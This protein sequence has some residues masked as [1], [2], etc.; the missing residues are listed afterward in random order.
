LAF[1]EIFVKYVWWF[2]G[3]LYGTL[4]IGGFFIFRWLYRVYLT[5]L[6]VRIWITP[7]KA[8]LKKSS[9]LSKKFTLTFKEAGNKIKEDYIIDQEAIYDEMTR[10]RK[11]K[12][13]EFI[14]GIE[15]PMIRTW[16]DSGIPT[17][18]K[19]EGIKL[20]GARTLHSAFDNKGFVEI[21]ELNKKPSVDMKT[22]LIFG[23]VLLGLVAVFFYGQSAGWFGKKAVAMAVPYFWMRRK[24][25]F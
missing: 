22:I 24:N 10:F 19:G 3:I 23:G 20:M 18:I 15:A 4:F 13:I 16:A 7:D 14:A 12:I 25:G 2:I 5:R 1:M 11:K 9:I 21:A 6:F 17:E 8:L